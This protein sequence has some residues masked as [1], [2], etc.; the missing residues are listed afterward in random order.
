M[1]VGLHPFLGVVAAAFGGILTS[2][3]PYHIAALKK[4][5]LL[6]HFPS[7]LYPILKGLE[8]GHKLQQSLLALALI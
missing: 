4:L 6:K 8:M 7:L 1:V 2:L 5:C 3:R